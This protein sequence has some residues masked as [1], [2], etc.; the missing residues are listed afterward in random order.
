MS[1]SKREGG[2][3][4]APHMTLGGKTA[5]FKCKQLLLKSFYLPLYCTTLTQ[6]IRVK[7]SATG[8]KEPYKTFIFPLD[9]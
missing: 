5:V 4:K 7:I 8:R 6:L 3:N 1:K 9:S 2:G